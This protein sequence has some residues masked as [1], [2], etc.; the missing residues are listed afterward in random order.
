MGRFFLYDHFW[1]L[2][3]QQYKLERECNMANEKT[4]EGKICRLEGLMDGIIPTDHY[5]ED[6]FMSLT[7]E[8]KV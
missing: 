4:R 8:H 7:N 3:V 6:E 5:L 1:S 2:Q